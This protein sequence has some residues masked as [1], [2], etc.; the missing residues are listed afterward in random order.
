MSDEGLLPGLLTTI[1][2][3]YPYMVE[4]EK[5]EWKQALSSLP[6][7]A[8]ILFM[9]APSLW[10][11]YLSKHQLLIP[12]HWELEFQHMNFGSTQTFSPQN[13]HLY[14]YIFTHT[15]T[16]RSSFLF[17]IPF[18]VFC[19]CFKNVISSHLSDFFLYILLCIYFLQIIVS[20]FVFDLLS[21]EQ[22]SY[23]SFE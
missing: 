19:S 3:L 7:R 17:F 23:C 12:S 22:G 2:S 13:I 6:I 11:N 16:S 4:T 15:Y 21:E 14:E 9:R 5:K 20:M 18:M 10:P 8:L 1:L